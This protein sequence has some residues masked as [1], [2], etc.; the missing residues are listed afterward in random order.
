MLGSFPDVKAIF[1]GTRGSDPR[2]NVGEFAPTDA[3]WPAVMRVHPVL[4]WT[5]AE[6][7]RFLRTLNLP[8]CSLY[9]QVCVRHKIESS[10]TTDMRLGLH[11][12]RTETRHSAK[13]KAAEERHLSS[14]TFARRNLYTLCTL[15]GFSL[16]YS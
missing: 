1:M 13:P 4:H 10:S 14:S 9:D 3:G 15:H 6:V 16:R 11:F 12:D 8:Y 2:G 7:W 5:Y